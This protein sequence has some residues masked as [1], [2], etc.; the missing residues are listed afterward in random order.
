MS[1]DFH[2]TKTKYFKYSSHYSRVEIYQSITDT[3]LN[4][5]DDNF[6]SKLKI[7]DFDKLYYNWKELLIYI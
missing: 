1:P 4:L 5:P 6:Q 3:I 7:F 2:Y